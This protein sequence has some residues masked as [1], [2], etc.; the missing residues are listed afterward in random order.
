MTRAGR[1]LATIPPLLLATASRAL[2]QSCAMCGASFGPNDPTSRAFS[3][4]I[5][6]LMAAPYTLV[7]TIAG[8]LIYMHRRAPGRRRAAIIDLVKAARVAHRPATA[9]GH[10]GEPS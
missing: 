6:F 10:Q 2:A 5:L 9:D 4:S 3:W 1:S 7:F 8:F